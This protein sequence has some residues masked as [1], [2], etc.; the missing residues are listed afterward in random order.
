[1]FHKYSINAAGYEHVMKKE[2]RK[3][4]Y[5][6]D[7]YDQNFDETGVLLMI[8]RFDPY[9]CKHLTEHLDK[10]RYEK[11]FEVINTQYIY[12]NETKYIY[13]NWFKNNHVLMI[14]SAY[15]T[16]K[17]FC[18]KELINKYNFKKVLFITYRRSL[19]H[20]LSLDL[21]EKYNFKNYLDEEKTNLRKHDRLI[22]QLNS[23][24]KLFYTSL[25][26]DNTPFYDLI[27]LDEIEG[28]LNHL[29]HSKIDQAQTFQNLTDLIETSTKILCLDGDMNDRSY[30]FISNITKDYKIIINKYVPI[31]KQYIFHRNEKD[32][33][34]LIDDD[35][36]KG[37]KI[38]IVSM[39]AGKITQNYFNKYEKK[40]NVIIHTGIDQNKKILEDVNKEWAKCDLLLYSPTVEA[41]IDF[42]IDHFDKCYGILSEKSTTARGFSQMLN[43]IRKF[44]SNTINI[45]VGLLLTNLIL[46]RFD[47]LKYQIYKQK[48]LTPLEIVLLHNQVEDYNSN[49]GDHTQAPLLT[50][51]IKMLTEKG[52]EYKFY[53]SQFRKKQSPFTFNDIA[54]AENLKY[55]QE[56]EDDP[57][58]WLD[59]LDLQ[60]KNKELSKDQN[61]SISKYE[62]KRIWKL[63]NVE[64]VNEEFLKDHYHKNHVVENYKNVISKDRKE[65][66]DDDIL[67]KQYFKKIDF[68]I[69]SK[70]QLNDITGIDT[71]NDV[72]KNIFDNKESKSLMNL[73]KSN[74]KLKN[75]LNYVNTIL[76]D[77]GF[78][79]IK[80]RKQKRIEGKMTNIFIYNVNIINIIQEYEKR[81]NE[82]LI[83]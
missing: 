11:E 30:D 79:I 17:T 81:V 10:S 36:K 28:V 15:G 73:Q 38:C 24:N 14:K 54:K 51:F 9:A 61:L 25:I 13:D 8:K 66:Y 64:D 60:R 31:K 20:S 18:F 75:Y 27:V 83:T 3:A 70:E 72:V 69:K 23:L 59:L 77:Y 7:E 63:K 49:R 12:N 80:S 19:A 40:Y 4:F 42:N 29:N 50:S 21:K 71:F 53:D 68:I 37:L 39:S 74:L 57:L 78:E 35:L 65:I 32:F 48:I 26:T 41:G 55:K 43:R 44:K 45:Y 6:N 52:H 62:Y 5:G 67:N 76:N 46:W 34:T 16:G 56:N 1:M 22:I 58:G 47:E 82:T 33:E 2:T